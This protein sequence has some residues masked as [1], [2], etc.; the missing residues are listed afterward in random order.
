[1]IIILSFIKWITVGRIPCGLE[2]K[3]FIFIQPKFS[4]FLKFAKKEPKNIP[5]NTPYREQEPNRKYMCLFPRKFKIKNSPLYS[6]KES[7]IVIVVAP[8]ENKGSDQLKK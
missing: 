3:T 8:S 1:M 4:F 2:E 6:G 7:G 5:V